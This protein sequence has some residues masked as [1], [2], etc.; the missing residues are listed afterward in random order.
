MQPE[1]ESNNKL[2]KRTVISSFLILLI[3]PLTIFF[4]IY[5]LN[6]RKYYLISLLIVFYSTIPFF[7]IFEKRKPQARELIVISV[8]SAIAVATSR[9]FYAA[10]V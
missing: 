4:G 7:M 5:F 6:D 10:A 1:S 9:L 2:S 3:I 8:L